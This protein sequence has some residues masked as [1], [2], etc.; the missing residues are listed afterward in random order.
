VKTTSTLSDAEV[1]QL[2]RTVEMF[3]AITEA[4]PDDF[5]SLEI[6]KET[7]AK[8]GRGHEALRVSRKLASAYEKQGEV[9][10]AILECEAVLQEQPGDADARRLLTSLQQAADRA[11]EPSPAPPLASD[12]KPTPPAG[13]P[14][15]VPSLAQLQRRAA[16]GDRLLANVLVAEKIATEQAL[17]PLLARL[18][19][20]RSGPADRAL[21][22]SLLQLIANEQYAKLDD[23]VTV[24]LDKSNLPFLPLATYD[25]DRDTASLLPLEACWQSCLVPFDAIGSS[26]LIATANP[27][28]MSARSTISA[29]LKKNIFWYISFPM[30]IIAALRRVHGLDSNKPQPAGAS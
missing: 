21:P 20:L 17:E 1:Q 11:A 28:D 26:V 8:L 2:L 4:Q 7:F 9:S 23:L 15:G 6:L 5:Q 16:E 27:F 25:V 12:S 30:E 24:L 10:K 18:K 14:A 13:A 29:L 3:E 19:T 22:L